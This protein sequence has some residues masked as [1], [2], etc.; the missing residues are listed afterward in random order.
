MPTS[1]KREQIM[2]AIVTRL[3][4]TAGV[5]GRVYRS[6]PDP[7]P[8]EECPFI[9]V[10]WSTENASPDT[11]PQLERTLTVSVSVFTRATSLSGVADSDADA[12]LVSAHSLLMADTQLGGLAIDMRLEDADTEIVAADMPAAKTTHQYSVKFRHSYADMTN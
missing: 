1:S 6:A 7:S 3:N 2:Q 12:I 11:V 9:A 10:S 4:T 5:N 8:R